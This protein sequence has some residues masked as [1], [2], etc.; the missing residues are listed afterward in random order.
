MVRLGDLLVERGALTSDQRDEILQV[1]QDRA[2]PFGV[3]AEELFGVRPSVVE[4]AWAEQHAMIATRL[5]PRGVDIDPAVL[6]LIERRQAWQ[7]GLIPVR[8]VGATLECV[9]APDYLARAMRFAGWRVPMDCRFSI[10]DRA[11]LATALGIH[12]P[13]EGLDAA[14][15]EQV[16]AQFVSAA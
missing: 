5:D 4:Q 11:M 9:T 14:F 13:I 8:Q 10:C 1:Q 16:M 7:F 3:L 15:V 6:S 12:Y 2:R